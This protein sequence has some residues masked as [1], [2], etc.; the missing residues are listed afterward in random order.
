[1]VSS[2]P[3]KR[4]AYT[5]VPEVRSFTASFVY[6]FFSPDERTNDTGISSAEFIKN[7]SAGKFDN[8]FIDTLNFRRF[9]PRFVRFSWAPTVDENRLKKVG[10]PNI[11]AVSI[12][13]NFN[14]IHNEQ[15]FT[16]DDY[17]NIY[18][19]DSGADEKV[20]FFIRRALD[21]IRQRQNPEEEESPLDILRLLKENTNKQISEQ[22]LT[23]TFFN[24]S[25]NGYM[26]VDKQGGAE[27]VADN[28]LKE[29]SSVRVR[30]QINN[31][32][33]NSLL[34]T[35]NENTIN[36]FDDD[37]HSLLNGAS[38]IQQQAIS[39]RNSSILDG[40]DYDFEILEFV[41]YHDIDPNSF[42]PTVQV[43]G[44][45]I[46]KKE[47]L[48]GGGSINHEPIIVENP[49][50][51]AAVDL[52]VRYGTT[53]SYNVR[54]IAYVQL[55]AEDTETN[56]VIALGF[57]ISSKP[58]GEVLTTTEEM[59]PP[60]PP[61]DFKVDWCY[62][63]KAGR[64]IWNFPVNPQRDIKKFQVFRRSSILEPFQLIKEF[65][66]DNS[67][68]LSPARETPDAQ[69]VEKM[70]SPQTYYIDFEFTKNSKF[71]YAICA[72]DAHGF[73]S[74]YSMQFEVSFNRFKN[75]IEKKLIS[76]SGAPKAYPNAFLLEDTFVDTIKDSGHQKVKL[77]FNP[78]YL[79]VTDARNNDLGLLKTGENTEYRLQMINIDLQ[80]QQ[81]VK[82]NLQDMRT[83]DKKPK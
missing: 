14:K 61:V 10:N 23:D 71:I 8:V 5:D 40:R 43:I 18:L 27:N 77:Y 33:I 45:I 47:I 65:D 20:D 83:G 30:T 53:Y 56:S 31:K 12:K 16:T 37:V 82:I 78:E 70:S 81:S 7:R 35:T 3:S 22:F 73:T 49:L 60:P 52:K 66:F 62:T 74:G 25:K 6:G 51:N 36:I 72:I 38:Q 59:V 13:D 4:I 21:E 2:L 28:V 24:L 1:M 11:S 29:I 75:K 17:T 44:Y 26:F 68:V 67:E 63:N 55:Q 34:K 79:S 19:Q 42:E 76:L 50:A 58:S 15:T 46:D 9:T 80:Q 32:V 39:Q 48:A 41:D 69:V 57:L 54:S 64:L